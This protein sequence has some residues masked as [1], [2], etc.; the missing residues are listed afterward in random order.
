MIADRVRLQLAEFNKLYVKKPTAPEP[1]NVRRMWAVLAALGHWFQL[2]DH[3]AIMMITHMDDGERANEIVSLLGCAFLTM[4][5]TIERMGWLKPDSEIL[6]LGVMMSIWLHW[7]RGMPDY[8]I[9]EDDTW[10][11]SIA[12]YAKR[13]GIDLEASGHS[14]IG[15]IMENLDFQKQER[16]LG[17]AKAG[18]WKWPKMVRSS[19]RS[20]NPSAC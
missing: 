11:E 9:G 20:S 4:L 18:K 16:T 10:R 7:S 15:E 8:G 2:D 14:S 5:D 19:C 17:Q 13:G 12:A 1:S 3:H 6:D